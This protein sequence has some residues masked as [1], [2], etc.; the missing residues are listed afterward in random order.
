MFC[1]LKQKGP[2][3]KKLHAEHASKRHSGQFAPAVLD[4]IK[5][6]VPSVR[7]TALFSQ[8]SLKNS[9]VWLHSHKN[10]LLPAL[11]SPCQMILVS[12]SGF[13][14]AV[15]G[16]F[17]W[18]ELWVYSLKLLI[19]VE[20]LQNMKKNI[21]QGGNI[22]PVIPKACFYHEII[23]RTF[24]E[25]FSNRICFKFNI[26]SEINLTHTDLII[27]NF[28]HLEGKFIKDTWYSMYIMK[29]KSLL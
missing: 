14:G 7:G 23:W 6:I 21:T 25:I 22:Y 10:F 12:G 29:N 24:S 9:V 4:R 20:T 28:I 13:A 11:I 8:G 16:A 1:H 19:G 5:E 27:D 3:K 2:S 15:L 26:N 18:V 17:L